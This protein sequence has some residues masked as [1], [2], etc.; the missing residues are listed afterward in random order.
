V[1]QIRYARFMNQ[2][3]DLFCFSFC[4]G[5]NKSVA[6]GIQEEVD[7]CNAN[8]MKAPEDR[9]GV[10]KE[11]VWLETVSTQR[12]QESHDAKER[13]NFKKESMAGLFPEDCKLRQFQGD[14]PS[15][16]TITG[17]AVA[18]DLEPTLVLEHETRVVRRTKVLGMDDALFKQHAARVFQGHADKNEKLLGMRIGD[19][20]KGLKKEIPIYTPN[21]VKLAID[22]AKQGL[23]PQPEPKGTASERQPS[24]PIRLGRP[25]FGRVGSS[26]FVYGTSS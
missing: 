4:Q 24:P 15:G 23:E 12:L 10:S 20:Y 8:S 18:R 16:G 22:A 13:H 3:C 19:A 21:Q 2:T 9:V 5:R 7:E 14:A 1:E 6:A 17:I 25:V 26:V 11:E